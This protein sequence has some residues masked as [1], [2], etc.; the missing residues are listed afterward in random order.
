MSRFG[1]QNGPFRDTKWIILKN[2]GFT[3]SVLFDSFTEKERICL[4]K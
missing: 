3:S 1:E 2:C 4:K